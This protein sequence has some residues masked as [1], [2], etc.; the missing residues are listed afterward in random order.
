MNN[1]NTASA[2]TVA[3]L[4]ACVTFSKCASAQDVSK[5]DNKEITFVGDAV[6]YSEPDLN[7]EY[8]SK[9]LCRAHQQ[10]TYALVW[11]GLAGGLAY[12]DAVQEVQDGMSP[13]FRPLTFGCLGVSAILNFSALVNEGKARRRLY[14][15]A[16]ATNVNQIKRTEQ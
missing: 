14:E 3:A 16:K 2:V 1:K 6:L 4:L 7:F 5:A 15:V 9:A 12:L 13:P 8:G 11:S 10:R